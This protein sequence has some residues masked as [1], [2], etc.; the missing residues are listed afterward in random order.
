[1]AKRLNI[2]SFPLPNMKV[3]VAD[4]KRIEKVGKCHKVNLQ[5]QD[6]NLES[7]FFTV[8]LGGVDVVLGTMLPGNVGSGTGTGT[9]FLETRCMGSSGNIIILKFNNYIL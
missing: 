9:A 7:P 2:F 6:F 3:M 8:S 4:S 5:I 1:M